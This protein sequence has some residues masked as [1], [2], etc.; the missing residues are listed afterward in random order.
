[1]LPWL[2]AEFED[3]RLFSWRRENKKFLKIA[4]GCQ[5]YATISVNYINTH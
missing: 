2:F 3:N 1:M 5:D 4:E